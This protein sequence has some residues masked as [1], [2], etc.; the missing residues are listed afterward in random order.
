MKSMFGAPL[1]SALAVCSLAACSASQQ[2]APMTPAASFAP[3]P[4]QSVNLSVVYGDEPIAIDEVLLVRE[5]DG[6]SRLLFFDG[7]A[8]CEDVA[9]PRV[10]PDGLVLSAH[11]DENVPAARWTFYPGNAAPSQLQLGPNEAAFRSGAGGGSLSITTDLD[12]LRFQAR[13]SY[14]PE[15]CE[16]V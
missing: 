1:L 11:M 8:S 12:G 4:D 13:G 7:D 5:A 16:N 9:D 3:P 10:Q 2:S 15:I 14:A 6:R